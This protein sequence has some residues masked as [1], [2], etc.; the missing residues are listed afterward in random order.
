[1]ITSGST[2]YQFQ[3]LSSVYNTKELNNLC[4]TN[5]IHQTSQSQIEEQ[6]QQQ[7][8][9]SGILNKN[10]IINLDLIQPE[11]LKI[12]EEKETQSSNLFKT[13]SN[14]KSS[15]NQKEEFNINSNIFSK[16]SS[17]TKQLSALESQQQSLLPSPL[18]FNQ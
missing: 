2:L 6:Q 3:S 4:N 17:P 1:M 9:Q 16:F 11:L 7:Q 8:Q 13:N 5:N 12:T 14:D 10:T 15:K 18:L